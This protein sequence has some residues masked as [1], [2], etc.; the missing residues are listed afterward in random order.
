MT[1]VELGNFVE[2]DG[3]IIGEAEAEAG[4]SGGTGAVLDVG[5]PECGTAGSDLEGGGGREKPELDR[6]ASRS[7]SFAARAS[8]SCSRR[9]S[10]SFSRAAASTGLA[11]PNGL[12]FVDEAPADFGEDSG[13]SPD[14]V[15]APLGSNSSFLLP[16]SWGVGGVEVVGLPLVDPVWDTVRRGAARQSLISSGD[17]LAPANGSPRLPPN[18]LL[19]SG[20]TSVGTDGLNLLPIVH[21]CS[22]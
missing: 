6:E 13:D 5:R 17:S 7:F 9:S 18:R 10:T 16:P 14:G 3:E 4:E 22:T 11:A 8:R 21:V 20:V 1:P 15:A 12:A 19:R 2:D